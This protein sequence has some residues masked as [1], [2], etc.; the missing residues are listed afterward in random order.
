MKLLRRPILQTLL[1]HQDEVSGAK[2]L[3]HKFVLAR[4]KKSSNDGQISMKNIEQYVLSLSFTEKSHIFTKQ[5]VTSRKRNG[6]HGKIVP[7]R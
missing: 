4:S 6:K 5:R 2:Y 7:V 3:L 1:N